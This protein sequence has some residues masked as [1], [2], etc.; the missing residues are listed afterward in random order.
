MHPICE[1]PG[2]Y[3][4]GQIVDHRVPRDQG[5]TD[6]RANLWALCHDHHAEKTRKDNAA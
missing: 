3:G 5:G 2:C 6:A 4:P 1:W